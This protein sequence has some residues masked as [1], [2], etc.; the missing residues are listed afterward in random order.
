MINNNKNQIKNKFS[1]TTFYKRKSYKKKQKNLQLYNLQKRLKYQNN[2]MN[3]NNKRLK[4][5]AHD[6]SIICALEINHY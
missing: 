1:I 5:D 4:I 3:P 2:Q 6:S